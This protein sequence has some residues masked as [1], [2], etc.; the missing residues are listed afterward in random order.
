M[1][2]PVI[3]SPVYAKEGDPI[4]DPVYMEDGESVQEPADAEDGASVQD[5][6]DAKE[7][8]VQDPASGDATESDLQDPTAPPDDGTETFIHDRKRTHSSEITPV[9]EEFTS[10]D[11]KTLRL[12]MTGLTSAN[13]DKMLN[14]L[15]KSF[16]VSGEGADTPIR[17]VDDS[18]IDAEKVGRVR[19]T[20]A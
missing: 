13:K 10:A 14:E 9:N 2:I 11:N 17:V 5:P 18:F 12:T 4:Q 7:E 20:A 3:G 15:R 19:E 1:C 8:P 6:A 16:R